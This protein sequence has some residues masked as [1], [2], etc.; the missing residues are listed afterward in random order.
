M[1]KSEND[2][3]KI[4]DKNIEKIDKVLEK[5]EQEIMS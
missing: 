2:I 1:K 3:Q 5:K 4:T